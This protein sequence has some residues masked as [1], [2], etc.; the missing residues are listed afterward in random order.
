MAPEYKKAA[1]KLKGIV[2]FVAL[3]CDVDSNKALCASFSIQ[4]FPTIKVFGAGV[5]GMPEDYNGPRTAKGLVD[6]AVAKLPMTQ[7]QKLGSGGKNSQSLD[8]FNK[9]VISFINIRTKS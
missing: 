8:E 3:D 7:V 6:Y 2:K 5:K 4:G 1:L 9:K